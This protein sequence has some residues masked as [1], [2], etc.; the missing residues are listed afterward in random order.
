[1]PPTAIDTAQYAAVLKSNGANAAYAILGGNQFIG[2]IKQ[3]KQ[4]G[5]SLDKIATVNLGATVDRIFLKQL[6]QDANGLWL[7]DSAWP[8][9]WDTNSPGAKEYISELKA[10]GLPNDRCNVGEFGV[11]AWSAV[12]IMADALKGSPTMDSRR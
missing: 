6:G 7:V 1:M 12:H 4:Q 8:G 5:L 2:L 9:S 11:Q 10:A 3:I